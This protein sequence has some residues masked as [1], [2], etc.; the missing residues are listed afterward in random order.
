MLERTAG[1]LETGSLRRLLPGSQKPLKSRRMLHSAFWNHGATELEYSHLWVAL[2][3]GPGIAV[4]KQE[5]MHSKS[6]SNASVGGFL[7]FLYPSGAVRFMRQYSLWK[8]DT[9]DSQRARAGF[10]RFGQRLYTS[11]AV[12]ASSK[13]VESAMNLPE[14]EVKEDNHTV[15]VTCEPSSDSKR[16]KSKRSNSSLKYFNSLQSTQDYDK[17]WRQFTMVDTKD[18]RLF[19]SPL[20]AYLSTSNRRVDAERA[21]SM[22]EEIRRTADH[23]EYGSLIKLFLNRGMFQSAME[24]YREGLTKFN[25]PVGS[26]MLLA[27]ALEKGHW[28]IACDIWIAFKRFREERPSL[29]YNIWLPSDELPNLPDLAIQLAGFVKV[30]SGKP[31][32]LRHTLDSSIFATFFTTRALLA[33]SDAKTLEPFKFNALLKVLQHWD[34]DTSER[35][36]QIIERLLKSGHTKL[37]IQ[38]YRKYR[39]RSTKKIS[40]PI[41]DK[42]LNVACEHYSILGM[43]QVLGDWFRFYSKPPG[44]SY[45]LCMSAFAKGGEVHTVKALFDQY[46]K[47]RGG[48][49]M[50]ENADDIAPLLDVHSR[51][52]ELPEVV[53]IFDG[54]EEKYGVQPS[55]KCWNI[56]INAYGKVLDIDGAFTQFQRLLTSSLQPDSYT[57][58]TLMGICT[59]RG[60]LDQAMELYQLVE[61]QGVA[62]SAAMI[63]C[64]VLG[65]IQE[66]RILQAEKICNDALAMDFKVSLTRMWNYL[67]TAYA[68]R[69][70]LENTNR[71]LRRMYDAGVEYD[72]ATYSALMQVLA[73]VKQP[74]RA[75]D[76][77][78]NVMHEAGV[79]VTSFH[80]AV[81]MGGYIAN[82]ELHKVFRVHSQMLRRNVKQTISTR[83]MTLKAS[84]LEDQRTFESGSQEAQWI[85]AEKYFYDAYIAPDA[86]EMV[87]SMRKGVGYEPLDTAYLSSYFGYLIYVLG[88]RNAF[89]R[90]T[91]LYERYIDNIPEHRR[92]ELPLK[93]LSALMVVSLRNNDYESVQQLWELAF[94]KAKKQ[95]QPFQVPEPP[96]GHKILPLHEQVLTIPL[97]IQMRSLKRQQKI[98]QLYRTKTEVERAGFVLDNKNWNIYIQCLAQSNRYKQA[99]DLCELRLMNGWTGWARIRWKEPE[100][101]RLAHAIRHMRKNKKPILLRPFHGTLLQLGKAYMDLQDKAAESQSARD[102]QD[103]LESK[104]RMTLH[105]LRTMERVDDELE[106]GIL[107]GS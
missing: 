66:D 13:P 18:R 43:Q 80:Y 35:Y 17:V 26:D 104:C 16:S 60:D 106:R 28:Q 83:L 31:S 47:S 25:V 99:F 11:F 107:R 75:S 8:S 94:E 22:F 73:M 42:V 59:M 95:G 102:I 49:E 44:H 40:R 5:Q 76:I 71:I 33:M 29:S 67:L 15:P 12:E 10:G 52:G 98:D 39:Q 45:R 101:N 64:I 97:S 46:V 65:H 53:K 100:R 41:L 32:G 36:E 69:R 86:Q 61:S 54:I 48:E 91:Q 92:E 3:R 37:A 57:Y 24:L 62:K 63:D 78:N 1:C 34:A 14:V 2:I 77:L 9:Q 88:Q 70:D 68:M 103:Y 87:D 38:C 20:L 90:A 72:G 50:I 27:H 93:I 7:D 81:V 96:E 23:D 89:Y 74:D 4:D 51:R 82:G 21:A 58:G 84:V 6:V 85:K 105:A 55:I 79:K 19:I 30:E 56:L